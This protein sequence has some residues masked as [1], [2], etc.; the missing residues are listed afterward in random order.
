MPDGR[1]VNEYTLVNA[2]GMT[3]KVINYGGIITMLTAPDRNGKFEDVVLGYES[4][5]DYLTKNMF[6]GAL[7]GRYG[8][9]IAR[10]KFSLDG[11]E[12]SLDTNN[13]PNH[14]H[15]GEGGF[16]RVYWNI[17]PVKAS[18]GVSLK[19][20]Y[21]SRDME[22]G[23]PGNLAVEV[24]YTLTNDNKLRIEYNASTDKKTIVNLTQ[25][26]YFN[27]SGGRRD[28]LDHELFIN[29]DKFLPD[30]AT[31]IPTG[32]LR[33]VAGTP[34]D[35]RKPFIIGARINDNDEQLKIGNGYDHTWVL[36][37]S[38]DRLNRAAVLY[39]KQTGRELT[40][41]T[42]EPGIQVYS[43]NFLNKELIGKNGFI[44][45][46]RTG[47]CLETQH[48]PDSPNKPEFPSV[49]L[50]PGEKYLTETVYSFT[51]R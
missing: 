30:D 44:N 50:N 45:D 32:E 38:Q 47:I 9:R 43:G 36:N 21:L 42:T 33:A 1:I 13:G 23:Y 18:D 48:F 24:Y 5:P 17:A 15:G 3:M 14:L 51:V 39:D 2:N 12:F 28:I 37:K 34:F 26:S 6:F 16:D 49:I 40:V 46:F 22:E 35:F 19:L 4:L 27:L 7:I 8:N 10:G 11:I 41:T 29:A 20:S 31:L 25:H